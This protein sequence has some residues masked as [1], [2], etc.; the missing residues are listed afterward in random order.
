MPGQAKSI[1]T[2][3]GVREMKLLLT[4]LKIMQRKHAGS[5]ELE[6][7]KSVSKYITE[8]ITDTKKTS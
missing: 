7:K 4:I 3:P 1:K 2:L 5:S 6:K 8:K